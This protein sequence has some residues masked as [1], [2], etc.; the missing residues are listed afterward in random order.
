M[1]KNNRNSFLQLI[2]TFANESYNPIL[3]ADVSDFQ[4]ASDFML[5]H[6]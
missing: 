3:E 6:K 4:I 1:N 2:E 5:I